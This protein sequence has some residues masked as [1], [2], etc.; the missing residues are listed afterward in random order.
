MDVYLSTGPWL[1]KF[2]GTLPLILIKPALAGVAIGIVLSILVFPKSCSSQALDQVADLLGPCLQV[3]ET[4]Q[5][6]LKCFGANLNEDRL[7][8]QKRLLIMRYEA[9]GQSF[10]FLP[11]EPSVSRWNANDI[12]GMK[13]H[14]RMFIIRLIGLVNF[15][16]L[17]V[18]RRAFETRDDN[19]GSLEAKTREQEEKF[20]DLGKFQN[21]AVSESTHIDIYRS[22]VILIT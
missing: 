7:S 8:G 19:Y 20:G 14:L 4:T 17:R 11:L 13:P 1:G 18:E 10:G 2:N 22:H 21:L 15:H 3:L 6:S 9:L 16:V 5:E 12:K